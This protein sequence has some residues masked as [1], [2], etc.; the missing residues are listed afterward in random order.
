MV[1]SC[2]T[3]DIPVQI[4]P[5][6]VSVRIGSP[7]SIATCVRC[8]P[9]SSARRPVTRTEAPPGNH[10]GYEGLPTEEGRRTCRRS[11]PSGFTTHS[12]DV[13]APRWSTPSNAIWPRV[14]DRSRSRFDRVSDTSF[15]ARNWVAFPCET[16]VVHSVQYP[17]V[18]APPHPLGI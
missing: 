17:E 15:R 1:P 7:V 6:S 14:A 5:G 3:A 13:P 4:T 18:D 16:R 11:E 2:D 8:G 12:A 10:D 9:G